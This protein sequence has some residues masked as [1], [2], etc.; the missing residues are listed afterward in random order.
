MPPLSKRLKS[1]AG[2]VHLSPAQRDEVDALIADLVRAEC[3]L[4]RARYRLQQIAEASASISMPRVVGTA[5]VQIGR[6]V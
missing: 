4:D 2:R 1:L 3:E 6:R 5:V